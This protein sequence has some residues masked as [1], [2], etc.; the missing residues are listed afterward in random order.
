[1]LRG[2]SILSVATFQSQTAQTLTGDELTAATA[3]CASV[4][5]AITKLIKPY[6]AEP[7]TLSNV[8][9]DAPASRDLI[10]PVR[11]ARSITSVYFRPGANGL[12]AN[13][14]SDYLLANT[15]GADYQLLIDDWIASHSSCAILRRVNGVWA[16][17]QY[18]P[19]GR[20]AGQQEGARGAILVNYTAGFATVPAEIES[21]A[22]LAVALLMEQKRTG[23]PEVSVSWNGG[24]VSYAG[25]FT[26]VGVLQTPTIA[27]WLQP[28]Q[29]TR[30]VGG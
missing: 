30:M 17:R 3:W 15:D 7:V 24:S 23:A 9:L 4:S 1:M 2:M 21:A 16:V 10:L 27:S 29:S 28:Y 20:L 18:R 14:T 22:V 8:I 11:P 5:A 13:F 19:P 6:H 12:A 25:P 26:S